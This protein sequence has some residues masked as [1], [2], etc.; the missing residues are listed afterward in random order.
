MKLKKFS[1]KHKMHW[2]K[3]LRLCKWMWE[4]SA[5]SFVGLLMTAVTFPHDIL[6]AVSL[7][8]SSVECF[9]AISCFLMERKLTVHQ[10]SVL[11]LKLP[12]ILTSSIKICT[13]IT[14]SKILITNKKYHVS[15]AEVFSVGTS[16]FS[17]CKINNDSTKS[18]LFYPVSWL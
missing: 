11:L 10:L 3:I 16:Q 8:C 18:C 4:L 7:I 5:V 12:N 9:R 17:G 14:F 2:E 13:V 1:K 15:A 6:F